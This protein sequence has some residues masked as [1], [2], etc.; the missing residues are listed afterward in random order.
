MTEKLLDTVPSTVETTFRVRF[1]ETDQMG[2]VHHTNY[3]VWFEEAR[4][5]WMRAHGSSYTE[6]EADGVSLAVSEVRAQFR[7][8]ARYDWRVTVRCRVASVRSRQ[9][10]FAYEVLNAE[11]GHILVTGQTIHICIDRAGQAR[12]IPHKWQVFLSQ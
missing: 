7:A 10:A 2:I 3:I 6:F 1:A 8:P 11:T 9:M 4:S 12:R 5:A